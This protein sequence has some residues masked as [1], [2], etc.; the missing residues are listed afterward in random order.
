MKKQ[1]KKRL[2][3]RVFTRLAY[4]ERVIIENRYCVDWK[5]ITEIAKELNRPKSTVSREIG[6]RPRKGIGRYTADKGQSRADN[7]AKRQ[8]RQGRITHTPLREYMLEKL[9]E[10]WS[11]EQVSIRLPIDYKKDEGMRISH[12][13][14]Y[15][16]IYAQ[17][18]TSGKVPKGKEDL[19]PYLARRYGRRRKKG[20]RAMQ[21]LYRP[22]LPSIEDRP[23]AVEKRKEVGHWED[24]TMVSRKSTVRLKT[25]N[26]RVSGII[27]IGKMK[28]GSISESN[29]V[30]LDRLSKIPTP[31]RKT[32]TRDRGTENFGYQ[33]IEKELNMTCWFAHP[34][35]SQERGSNENGNGLIRRP[36]PKKTDFDFVSDDDIRALER[37]L[38][39]RPRKRLGGLTPY[40]VFFRATGVA[41]EC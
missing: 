15:Q 20:F 16:Y 18:K 10:G 9:K 41:L 7:N 34:Y 22:Q 6:G 8:G 14:I 25:I 3:K 23:K 35:S 4:K 24:D 28:D 30:V 26:E 2:G 32:L 1:G 5:S 17:V 12:E 21:K 11:P 33:E 19:R 29:R 39:N 31:A 13:A 37:R 27:L 36:Y 38:N 40:E